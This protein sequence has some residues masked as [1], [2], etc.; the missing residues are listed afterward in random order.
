[1]SVSVRFAPGAAALSRAVMGG[2]KVASQASVWGSE[3]PAEAHML[4]SSVSFAC[5]ECQMQVLHGQMLDK[6]YGFAQNDGNGGLVLMR[7]RSSKT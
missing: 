2:A 3:S 5:G 1:M 6:T 4:S 7:A